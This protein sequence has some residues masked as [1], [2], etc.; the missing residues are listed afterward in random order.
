MISQCK[1]LQR[2]SS[3]WID[4]A[5]KLIGRKITSVGKWFRADR[6]AAALLDVSWA[7]N[8]GDGRDENQVE[9]DKVGEHVDVD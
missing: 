3:A 1:K 4:I 9:R 8:C 7:A 5:V 2:P 6:E